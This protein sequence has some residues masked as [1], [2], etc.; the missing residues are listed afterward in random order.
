MLFQRLK[1]RRLV[2]YDAER[3]VTQSLDDCLR[4]QLVGVRLQIT[5][6]GDAQVFEQF[7]IRTRGRGLNAGSRNPDPD[8][9]PDLFAAMAYFSMG[10]KLPAIIY[11]HARPNI[12]KLYR[13]VSR[14]SG[15]MS[16]A[17]AV[18]EVLDLPAHYN[19]Q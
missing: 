10:F 16:L 8:E 13:Y 12:T 1:E 3:V 2:H 5:P 11:S 7:M 15:V 19:Y 9:N 6:V 4:N 14:S 18:Q 17:A